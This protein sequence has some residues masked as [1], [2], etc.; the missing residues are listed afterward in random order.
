MDDMHSWLDGLLSDSRIQL[1]YWK[2]QELDD[3]D[4]WVGI[5]AASLQSGDAINGR[6]V[7]LT[8]AD[9]HSRYAIAA[10]IAEL[11]EQ[12][13][14]DG[15]FLDGMELGCDGTAARKKLDAL[16]NHF[17]EEGRGLCLVLDGMSECPCGREVLRYLGQKL[18]ESR[19]NPDEGVQLFVVLTEQLPIPALLRNC[20]LQMRLQLPNE[21][22]RMAYLE[23]YGKTLR[24]YLSLAIF[25]QCTEGVSYVQLQDLIGL[26][27]GYLDSLDGRGMSEKELKEFLAAQ[28]PVQTKDPM[29]QTL[30]D[31][32]QELV[33]HFKKMPA[34]V[35]VPVQV[36]TTVTSAVV[37]P[38]PVS[39]T[40][41]GTSRESIENAPPI[42]VANDLWGKDIVEEIRKKAEQI[43]QQS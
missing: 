4:G 32:V 33:E 42:E 24:N 28:M 13:E 10:Q 9:S 1:E 7:L 21:E 3:F 16:L 29:L 11:L 19:M 31:S 18:C 8:G 17:F 34:S 25:A 2:A 26:A 15:L 14:F 36:Q 20:L 37:N 38:T 5:L 41:G 43:M 23:Q 27:E 40:E 39:N 12:A 6:G 35:P 30:C 22:R